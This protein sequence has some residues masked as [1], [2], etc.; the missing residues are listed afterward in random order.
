[1]TQA[2]YRNRKDNSA[3]Q[4]GSAL[5]LF[6]KYHLFSI[7]IVPVFILF[8]Y[9][10]FYPVFCYWAKSHQS[11]P[12]FCDVYQKEKTFEFLYLLT[13]FN[14]LLWRESVL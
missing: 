6:V 2:R 1:M 10:Y 14:C 5:L 8:S 9:A 7:V 12:F 4:N 3:E 11:P 13:I